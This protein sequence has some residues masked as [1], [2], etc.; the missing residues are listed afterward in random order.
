MYLTQTFFLQAM[1]LRRREQAAADSAPAVGEQQQ[2]TTLP[3]L[4]G[5]K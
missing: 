1:A 5:R 4:S 2:D 3:P